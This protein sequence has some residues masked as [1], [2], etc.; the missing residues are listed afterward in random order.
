MTSTNAG[1]APRW[2]LALSD[3]THWV[4][5]M[6][7]TQLTSLMETNPID[8]GHVVRVLEYLGNP[9]QNKRYVVR[10]NCCCT[11]YIRRVIIA[12]QLEVLRRD[13]EIH[14]NP[15]NVQPDAQNAAAQPAADSAAAPPA[16]GG[17]GQPPT[18]NPM[19]GYGQP[20][21]PMPGYG[22]P[23]NAMGGY[24]QPPASVGGYGQP[25]AASMGGYGQA[26]VASGGYNGGQ[27]YGGGQQFGLQ[28]T[29]YN[30]QGGGPTARGD[31]ERIVPIRELTQYSN[32]FTIKVLVSLGVLRCVQVQ[33][34]CVRH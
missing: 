14:G 20:P 13:E 11:P 6:L 32:R 22:Q 8:R 27:S 17:Y 9:I 25:P 31:M 16:A 26:P 23:H 3:G 5:V 15:Q 21:K 10:Q 2:R 12:L 33:R 30:G 1:Q 19:G 24:G 28:P 4:S 18:N 29:R 7:A 34:C